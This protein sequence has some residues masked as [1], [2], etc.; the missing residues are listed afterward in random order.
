M[1]QMKTV[2]TTRYSVSHSGI[3]PIGW[4]SRSDWRTTRPGERFNAPKPPPGEH[5]RSR[6]PRQLTTATHPSGRSL[7]PSPPSCRC[8]CDDVFTG[9]DR[10]KEEAQE[11]EEG[12]ENGQGWAREDEVS[13]WARGRRPRGTIVCQEGTGRSC[14]CLWFTVLDFPSVSPSLS[15]SHTPTPT[16][17]HS[18]I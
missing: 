13:P 5:R 18:V 10:A 12:E 2:Q 16:G 4:A 3:V 7:P 17:T 11:E 8:I 6:Q 14:F 1:G 9:T 15:L